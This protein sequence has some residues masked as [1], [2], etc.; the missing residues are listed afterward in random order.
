VLGLQHYSGAGGVR[1]VLRGH[2]ATAYSGVFTTY[3]SGSRQA[4]P[5]VLVAL[6]LGALACAGLL[7]WLDRK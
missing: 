2:G 5:I 6:A 7:A 1:Y 3:E 4:L